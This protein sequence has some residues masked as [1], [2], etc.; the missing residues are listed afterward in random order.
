MKITGG[1]AE[2]PA[3]ARW[4]VHQWI[5]GV[6]GGEGRGIPLITTLLDPHRQRRRP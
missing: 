1:R 4:F 5:V 6:L 3:A 2:H